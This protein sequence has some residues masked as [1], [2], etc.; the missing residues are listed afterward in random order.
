[1]KKQ[2]ALKGKGGID[3]VAKFLIGNFKFGSFQ[4]RLVSEIYRKLGD[5][6]VILLIFEKFYRRSQS[7]VSLTVLISGTQEDLFI[8]VVAAAERNKEMLFSE[9]KLGASE[10][11]VSQ[12]VKH[13]TDY[14]FEITES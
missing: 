8:D 5:K 7:T 6:E 13:L 12:A 2:V 11:F 14:G 3:R 10:N 4:P 1:M 9:F